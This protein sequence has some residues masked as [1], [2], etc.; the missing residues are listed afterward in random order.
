MIKVAINGFG[1][2]GRTT[3]RAGFGNQA[4]EFV[5]INDLGEL[6]T[7]AHLLKYDSIFGRFEGKVETKEGLLIVDGKEIRFLNEKDPAKLPWKELGVDV[8]IESTGVFTHREGAA[9]HLKAGAKK[10]LISAPAK[11]PDVTLVLG[12][13][14]ASYDPERHAIISMASCTTNCLAPVAKLLN[15]EFGIER[16]F[17]TTVH[18]YTM[19][20]RLLDAPHRDLRRARAAAISLVPTTTGAAKA[21]GLVLPELAGK[22]D[23]MAIRA[24]VPNISLVDLVVVLKRGASVEEINDAFKRA[25]QTSFEGIIEYTEEPLVSV[26][27]I[28]NPHSAVVDGLS[29]RVIDNLA[30]VLAW[31]DNEYAYSA[32]LIDLIAKVIGPSIK[33]KG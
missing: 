32:K 1:R 6:E 13:N 30:K 33:F 21:I 12:V 26:D 9:N 25:S 5:A 23:G 8:V 28:G 3:F 22:L 10:V 24:P 31:Y 7:M 11:D 27:I 20:Q 29:T 16:G 17:M 14:E 15:D 18:A 4:I 19:G 2:I